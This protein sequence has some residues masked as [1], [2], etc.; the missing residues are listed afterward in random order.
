MREGSGRDHGAAVSR[1][2]R[3]TARSV[4][5]PCPSSTSDC[6]NGGAPPTASASAIS[7]NT[8]EGIKRFTEELIARVDRAVATGTVLL[9]ADSGFWNTKVFERLENAGW[10]H[11]M[12]SRNSRAR[13]SRMR[14]S[15]AVPARRSLRT[16]T[17]RARPASADAC[18]ARAKRVS[19]RDRSV[20]SE[21][22]PL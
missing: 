7:A 13:F 17:K 16:S 14:A 2:A 8:Q 9:R 12:P 11:S 19:V 10:Q 15:P 4:S 20:L 3:A 22:R 6:T 21:V 1:R 5:Q 18:S